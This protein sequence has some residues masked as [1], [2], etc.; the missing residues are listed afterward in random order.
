MGWGAEQI[1][2]S[3]ELVSRLRGIA[4]LE[5]GVLFLAVLGYSVTQ[6]DGTKWHHVRRGGDVILHLYLGRVYFKSSGNQWCSESW[7][8][9]ADCLR[10]IG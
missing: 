4:S 5:E 10:E 2:E 8:A 6:V 7:D 3:R 9:L 1:R